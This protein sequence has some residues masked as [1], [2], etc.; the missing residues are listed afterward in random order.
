MMNIHNI[1]N[2]FKQIRQLRIKGLINKQK[3][4]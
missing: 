2:I 3:P 1:Y 4:N